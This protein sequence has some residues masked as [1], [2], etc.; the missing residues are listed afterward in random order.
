MSE[1]QKGIKIVFGPVHPVIEKEEIIEVPSEKAGEK[2]IINNKD[3]MKEEVLEIQANSHQ[4]KRDKDGNIISRTSE[5]GTVLTNNDKELN[6]E[7]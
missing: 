2:R 1:P 6:E 4:I 7:R 5:N 3:L